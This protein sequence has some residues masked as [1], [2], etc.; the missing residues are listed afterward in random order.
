[1]TENT[2]LRISE[3]IAQVGA[4]DESHFRRKFKKATG[5]TLTQCRKLHDL[6]AE[7]DGDGKNNSQSNWPVNS[8]IGQQIV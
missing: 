8:E 2:D 5:L 3:I 6:W 4:G 1:M 7:S